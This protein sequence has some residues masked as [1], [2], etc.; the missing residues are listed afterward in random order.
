MEVLGLEPTVEAKQHTIEG[1]IE[2]L[3][4]A[5]GEAARPERT[6]K[7]KRIGANE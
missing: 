5:Q 1:L 2:T 6:D 3:L 7:G 4:R